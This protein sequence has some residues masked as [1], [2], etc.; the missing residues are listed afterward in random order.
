MRRLKHPHRTQHLDVEP[1]DIEQLQPQ[2]AFRFSC[3]Q[4]GECCFDQLV[5]LDPFDLFDL[6]RLGALPE[7]TTTTDL[8]AQGYVQL[9]LFKDEWRCALVMPR[10]QRGTKCRFL[11]PS[12]SERG[13]VLRWFCELHQRGAKPLVCISSPIA[14]DMTGAFYLVAPVDLCPG[15]KQG[16]PE[17]LQGY[18]GRLQLT[19]RIDEA[20]W[21]QQLL[22][23]FDQM[24]LLNKRE[25]LKEYLT[26]LFC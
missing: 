15:M 23:D 6:S 13:D 11:T 22:Y 14:R 25:N 4:C 18:L 3:T 17:R 19:Q 8:F 26:A 1:S 2:D 16:E 24:S 21:F 20:L 10:F 9:L 5:L 12:L 7:I